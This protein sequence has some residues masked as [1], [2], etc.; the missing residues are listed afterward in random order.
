MCAEARVGNFVGHEGILYA[1]LA[2]YSVRATV[3][4]STYSLS[5]H[6]ALRLVEDHPVVALQL[7]TALGRAICRQGMEFE[8]SA[9]SLRKKRMVREASRKTENGS[10]DTDLVEDEAAPP[11]ADTSSLAKKRRLLFAVLRPITRSLSKVHVDGPLRGPVIAEAAVPRPAAVGKRRQPLPQRAHSCPFIQAGYDDPGVLTLPST[12]ASAG[13]QRKDDYGFEELSV[14]LRD[15]NPR[16]RRQM[17]R[18]RTYSGPFCQTTAKPVPPL[19]EMPVE[20]L[21]PRAGT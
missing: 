18:S 7:Q 1:G 17:K 10:N 15:A 4:C 11:S 14:V 16:E 21:R 20:A 8:R 19:V 6:D 13:R 9:R 12:E 3:Q 5:K 2:Q